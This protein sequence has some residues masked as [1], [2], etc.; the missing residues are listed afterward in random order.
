MHFVEIGNP[1]SPTVVFSHGWGRT[2]SDFF[3]TAEALNGCIHGILLDLPGF[4]ESTRPDKAWSTVDYANHVHDFL[5]QLGV[6]KFVWV[7]HSFGGRIGLRLA[8]LYPNTVK[9]LVLV[10]SAG[11][12]RQRSF[13]SKLKS[14]FRSQLFKFKK[15]RAKSEAE[16]QALEAQYGSTDYIESRT[17]GL[18]D[19]FLK[20][21]NEDQSSELPQISCTTQLLYGGQD[22]ETPVEIG[23]RICDLIPSSEITVLPEMGHIDILNRGRHIIALRIKELV[24]RSDA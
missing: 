3:A 5:T 24:N 11:I 8:A 12:P 17:I 6:S 7:G 16:I 1:K 13:S 20:T 19:I 2:H 15:N 4:G 21:V 18:R 23:Q 22:L 14:K 10:G 9:G